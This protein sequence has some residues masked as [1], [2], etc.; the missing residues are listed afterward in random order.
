[1]KTS[2]NPFRDNTTIQYQLRSAAQITIA[3]Y[4]AKGNQVKI[5]VDKKQGAG[6]YSEQFNGSNLG[7]GVYF[8]K[9]IK[10]GIVK[11]TL[12]AVKG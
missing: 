8:I 4:D 3:V 1:M 6:N 2:P 5:L 12:K 9:I 10:D 7:A 11:Q